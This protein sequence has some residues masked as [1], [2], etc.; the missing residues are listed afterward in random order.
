[1]VWEYNR[2]AEYNTAVHDVSAS[3]L[4]AKY[5]HS[6]QFLW[7][8]LGYF[9]PLVLFVTLLISVFG[10]WVMFALDFKVRVDSRLARDGPQIPWYFA[11]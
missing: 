10:F 11:L 2:E 3:V 5:L 6:S 7:I 1:M 9:E 4:N 8:F